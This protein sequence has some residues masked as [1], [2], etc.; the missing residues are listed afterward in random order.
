FAK[1]GIT[2]TFH[3]SGVGVR[4]QAPSVKKK[5][6]GLR[7]ISFL[8]LVLGIAIPGYFI[9]NK[10][11]APKIAKR[12]YFPEH[13][14]AIL[15]IESI[16]QNPEDQQIADAITAEVINVASP[17]LGITVTDRKTV[18][19]FQGKKIDSKT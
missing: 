14:L 13:R 9:L 4:T 3:L 5:F 6:I 15:P 12:S 18:M 16:R 7:L 17:L 10:K 1:F 19:S 2:G 11:E 8:L